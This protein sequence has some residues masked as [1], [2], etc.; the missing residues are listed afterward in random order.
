MIGKGSRLLLQSKHNKPSQPEFY[1]LKN[2][3]KSPA[4]RVIQLLGKQLKILLAGIHFLSQ[5][6]K[7][8]LS[9][10]YQSTQMIG[11]GSRLLL[12]SKHNKPSQP[13]FYSLKNTHKSPAW[14]VIQLQGNESNEQMPTL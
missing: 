4:W 9:L 8:L 10:K 14:R 12:Q 11:K 5:L 1:S 7:I 3:H 6:E 2:T 13:E